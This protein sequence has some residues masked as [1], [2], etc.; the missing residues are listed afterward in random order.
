MKTRTYFEDKHRIT[1]E[2][3]KLEKAEAELKCIER[4]LKS[5][6]LGQLTEEVAKKFVKNSREALRDMYKEKIPEVNEYTG[7]KNNKEAMLEQMQ[8]P[9]APGT[10][11]FGAILMA[12]AL[13][14]FDFG[15]TVTINKERLEKHLN[16]FRF[17]TSDPEIIEPMMTSVH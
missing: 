17:I 10:Q 1:V 7:L 6:K 11:N 16:E 2:I 9:I 12:G 8:L 15:D 5:H 4:F 14:V 3:A 13:Y